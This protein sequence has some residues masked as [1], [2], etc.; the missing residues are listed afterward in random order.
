MIGYWK[1]RSVLI[2][3][4]EG[5]LG[6]HLTKKMIE[7]GAKVVGVDI[8]THRKN[9]ILNSKD[10]KNIKVIKG[11]VTNYKLM[12]K[13]LLKNKI[14]VVFHLAAKA[15]VNEC[16]NNPLEAFSTNI[17]GTWTL[18]EACRNI[19]HIESII[20]AS[21]DKA[22]GIHEKLPYKET[23]PLKGVYPYDVSK[24][25]AD[26]IAYS[27]YYTFGLPIVITRCGN[28]FG[29]GDFSFSRIVP[30]TIRSIILEKPVLIRSDGTYTRD[31]VYV[32]DIV[33]GYVLI[34]EKTNKLKLYGE[35]FNLSYENP[36]SVIELVKKIYKI[37]NR[38]ENYKILNK[39]RYE[40]KHQYLSSRK[41]IE[42]LGWKPKYS[43]EEGLK[44]T[45]RW[46]ENYFKKN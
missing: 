11:S 28:I 7:L 6:S 14:N 30:D 29:P 38:K 20:V 10:Y 22:Y 23:A 16:L 43:L 5:F 39:V 32:E 24:S 1:N 21:S 36:I 27:Y 40:I 8:K 35:A 18:L 44:I 15:I 13:V 33:E 12:K 19:K 45:I 31:Y 25:C 17:K 9:T 3:G 42:V 2:T 34:A 26:L 4:Y 37:T 41:A 46:Y